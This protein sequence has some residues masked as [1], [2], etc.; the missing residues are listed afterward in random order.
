MAIE[1]ERRRRILRAGAAAF[2]GGLAGCSGYLEDDGAAM[3]SGDE[4]NETTSTATTAREEIELPVDGE[5]ER[6]EYGETASSRLTE[7]APR[8]PAYDG[9][10]EPWTIV[11]SEGDV[12]TVSMESEAGDTYLYLLDADGNL[13]AENDDR[14]GLLDLD[15]EIAGH[16]LPADG[17][18]VVLAAS[19]SDGVDFSYDLSVR[20]GVQGEKIDLRSI[21]VGETATGKVDVDD[22]QHHEY[23][24]FEPV[25]LGVTSEQTITIEMSSEEADT[26]VAVEDSTG[27]VVAEDDDGGDGL[28]SRIASFPA[29]AGEEYTV[30]ATSY[31]GSV[32]F[33]YALGVEETDASDGR[34]LR[35]IEI[36]ETARGEIDR[37]DP[38]DSRFNGYLEPVSLQADGGETVSIE[39]TSRDGDT[40][41][42][43]LDPSGD[44]IAE[45][46]D[47]ASGLNSRIGVVELAEA[48]EYTVVAGGYRTTGFFEYE[49]SVTER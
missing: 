30:V 14:G 37:S 9:H 38:Q 16:E 43:L 25:T 7:S 44:V 46:D 1:D 31:G 48:G 10:Y 3:T 11:G 26:L 24:F 47:G 6:I 49:L 29:A 8:D 27:T 19:Y 40:Y 5:A 45:N 20:E 15:A 35:E 36:G 28:N 22:P 33:E 41:L 32:G 21:E 17:T 12:V 39:M 42:Y 34:D 18:Y 13:L 23:G 4:S 2:V